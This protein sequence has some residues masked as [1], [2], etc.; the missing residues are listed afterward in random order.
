MYC[1]PCGESPSGKA[2][3]RAREDRQLQTS[4]AAAKTA[5]QAAGLAAIDLVCRLSD[6]ARCDPPNKTYQGLPPL[7]TDEETNI[8]DLSVLALPK[9]PKSITQI[10]LGPGPLQRHALAGL[11]FQRLTIGGGSLFEFCRPVLASSKIG[12]RISRFFEIFF[13]ARPLAL[14]ETAWRGRTW[15]RGDEP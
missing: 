9:A 10:V 8:R 7:Q 6:K 11:F 3:L 1:Q 2:Q 14:G 5:A 15:A 13:T 12:K 4:P